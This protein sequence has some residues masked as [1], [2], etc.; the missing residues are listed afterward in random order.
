MV[1]S[2]ANGLGTGAMARMV[3]DSAALKNR[4]E[5]LTQQSTDGRR[6]QLYGDEGPRA[7]EAIDLRAEIARRDVTGQGITRALG[8]TESSQLVLTRIAGIAR[9]FIGQANTLRAGESASIGVTAA[10][11]RSAIAEV[12]ALLNEQSGGRYLF[13]GTDTATRP[14]PGELGSSQM[15]QRISA[16]MAGMASGGTAATTLGSTLAAATDRSVGQSP[17]SEFLEGAGYAED[18]RTSLMADGTA[19]PTGLWAN[20]NADAVSAPGGTGSWSRDLLRGLMTLA[21]LPDAAGASGAELEK[22]LSSVR[23]SLSASNDA[24]AVEAGTLGQTQARLSAARTRHEEVGTALKS[25]LA[26]I[27]E[28]DLA[29]T[30]VAMQDARTRLEASYKALSIFSELTLSNFLR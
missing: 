8:R 1:S 12:G 13:G 6:V 19:L 23:S 20:R 7:R 26:D 25:Q 29:D 2:I 5:A 11:A 22:V 24:L 3:A 21:A 16:A 27:E 17:F 10:A 30:L 15:A 18:R 28:V 9:D 4:I 14:V